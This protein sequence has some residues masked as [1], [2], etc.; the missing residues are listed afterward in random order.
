ML[1]PYD[2]ILTKEDFLFVVK[3]YEEF[4][5]YII[6]SPKYDP[7]RLAKTRFREKTWKML[8]DEWSRIN[9]PLDPTSSISENLSYYLKDYKQTVDGFII[10][11]QDIKEIFRAKDGISRLIY[12]ESEEKQNRIRKNTRKISN[13]LLNVIQEDNLGANRIFFV[14]R[15]N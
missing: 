8:G 4:D 2:F 14:W 3:N 7:Y 9:N 6:A 1:R 15:R 12:E 13:F 11:R 10:S 5:G